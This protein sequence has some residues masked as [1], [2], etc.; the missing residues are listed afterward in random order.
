MA[1]QTK[2]VAGVAKDQ[3]AGHAI[4][5]NKGMKGFFRLSV[6]GPTLS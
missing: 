5:T 4:M 6:L 2:H 3:L 1:T